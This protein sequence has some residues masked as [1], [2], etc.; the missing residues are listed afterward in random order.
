MVCKSSL[1]I[2][3]LTVTIE[4][5]ELEVTGISTE[6]GSVLVVCIGSPSIGL[7]V[8]TEDTVSTESPDLTEFLVC[9]VVEDI[10]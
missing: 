5:E 4:V 3:D 10:T 9:I 7:S 8:V 6:V 1:A 2:V